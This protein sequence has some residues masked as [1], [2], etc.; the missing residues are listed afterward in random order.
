VCLEVVGM[1]VGDEVEMEYV[2]VVVGVDVCFENDRV[3]V[4]V[5]SE[6]VG[7]LTAPTTTDPMFIC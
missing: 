2:G 7:D 3:A 4:G 1:P 5:G 6:D